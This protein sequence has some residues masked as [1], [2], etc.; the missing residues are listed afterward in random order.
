M[1]A[2]GQVMISAAD[3]LI[4]GAV[5]YAFMPHHFGLRLGAVL[6]AY[7]VAQVLAVTSHV[8]AGAGIF[9]LVVVAILVRV[10]P[11]APR[12]ALAAAL[13]MFRI[14]YYVIPLCIAVVAATMTEVSLTR[15]RA[16]QRV[17]SGLPSAALDRG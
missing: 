9:E 3:W 14:V 17:Q 13:V 5:L 12:A 7:M 2:G 4:T 8:P 1:L 10:D 16:A 15:L 6:G 11:V